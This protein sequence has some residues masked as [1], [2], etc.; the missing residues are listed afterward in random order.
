MPPIENTPTSTD[1]TTANVQPPRRPVNAVPGAVR[2]SQAPAP[3]T[4]RP[5][6]PR[7]PGG[8]RPQRPVPS[9]QPGANSQ[10][11]TPPRQSVAGTPRPAGPRQPRPGSSSVTRPMPGTENRAAPPVRRRRKKV[12]QTKQTLLRIGLAAV[13]IALIAATGLLIK[14]CIG[15]VKKPGDTPSKPAVSETQPDAPE[16]AVPH[17]TATASVG[18]QGDLLMHRPIILSGKQGDSGYDFSS[19]FRYTKQFTQPLDYAIANLETTLAGDAFPY[20]GY[21]AHNCPDALAD[22]AK[23]AG[24]DMLLTANNHCCDTHMEGVDRTLQQVR[25]RGITTLGTRLSESEKRYEVV[26]VNGIRIGMVCY[27]YAMGVDNKGVCM[28]GADTYVKNPAQINYFTENNLDALYSEVQQC[29][30]G[31]KAEGAEATMLFIHWGTEYE[32]TENA[33]QRAIAQRMCN[34]GFDVIVGGHPHVVQPMDLLTSSTDPDHRT[35]CIYSIG[36][37]ISNQFVDQMTNQTSG[38]TEDGML[39]TV[40][41]EKYGDGGVYLRNVEILPTWI[42]RTENG[43]KTDYSMVPLD[44]TNREQWQNKYSLT[45]TQVTGA[46]DSYNRT[47]AIVGPGLQTVNNYLTQ[48]K[49]LR[50]GT[51]AP[52]LIDTP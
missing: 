40:N 15:L 50:E 28:N 49:T 16:A 11:V 23:D 33:T 22:A 21:P 41:F 36:N 20:Q 32:L 47:M 18:T 46:A 34:M 52:E 3:G 13:I 27:T 29:F 19:V 51:T 37:A 43:E 30:D 35:V 12:N 42:I 38:H 14:L 17:V 24:F 10:R 48:Q 25:Q 7:Q 9:R 45:G 44:Y 31:M 8:P 1:S 5:A 6:A 26:E 4:N 2:P 39:F